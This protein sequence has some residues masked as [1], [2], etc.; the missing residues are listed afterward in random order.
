MKTLDNIKRKI[1]LM[2]SVQVKAG[3]AAKFVV[4]QRQ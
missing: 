4:N 2:V 1:V 3:D